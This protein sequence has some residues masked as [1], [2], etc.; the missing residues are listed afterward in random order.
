[1]VSREVSVGILE[2]RFGCGHQLRVRIALPQRRTS[3]RGGHR[4]DIGIVREAGMRMMIEDRNLLN[5]RQEAAVDLLH[6]IGT[7]QWLGLPQQRRGGSRHYENNQQ[8][9]GLQVH[10]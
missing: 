10:S 3:W 2:E 6:T 1:M 7:R 9:P 8:N 5:L 4:V